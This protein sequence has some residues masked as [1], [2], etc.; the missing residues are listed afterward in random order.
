MS[1]R[2]GVQTHFDAAHHLVDYAGACA[3]V[4]GHRW[5]VQAIWESSQ[6][7]NLG[8]T[9]DFKMLKVIL[10]RVVDVYDHQDLNSI[11]VN[12]PTA[13]NIAATIY[14]HLKDEQFGDYLHSV[15]I[16]E[17]PDCKVLYKED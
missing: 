6:L 17:T 1:Y 7:D 14:S 11:L 5:T 2:I 10:S 8:M 16:F 4:H 3:R 9:F 13:E 12:N 15:A